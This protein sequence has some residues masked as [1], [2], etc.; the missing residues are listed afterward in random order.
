MNLAGVVREIRNEAKLGAR[1]N[2]TRA[3][4]QARLVRKGEEILKREKLVTTAA[5]TWLQKVVLDITANV[6]KG[7]RNMPRAAAGQL[8]IWPDMKP[9]EGYEALKK[10]ARQYRNVFRRYQTAIR[11]IGLLEVEFGEDK[12]RL[13]STTSLKAA[14]QVA[15]ATAEDIALLEDIA[16]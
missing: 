1:E 10:Y 4:W 11:F 3:D 5:R 9:L 13:A 16:A 12:A 14:L 7:A 15:G 8:A 2:E 6:L